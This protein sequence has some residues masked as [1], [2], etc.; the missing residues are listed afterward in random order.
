[1]L[2][3][4]IEDRFGDYIDV[5]AEPDPGL[6]GRFEVKL[7]GAS[8]TCVENGVLM[9]KSTSF[10]VGHGKCSN[11]RFDLLG[12]RDFEVEAIEEVLDD[13]VINSVVDGSM[14]EHAKAVAGGA[15]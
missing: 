3:R 14:S 7:E 2:S 12:A 10:L 9:D 5:V 8:A 13:V 6:T 1:M 15:T 11:A 4:K